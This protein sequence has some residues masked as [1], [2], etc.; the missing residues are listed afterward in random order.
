[1]VLNK[2]LFS[3]LKICAGRS[4]GQENPPAA[5]KIWEGMGKEIYQNLLVRKSAELIVQGLATCQLTSV[6]V[7]ESGIYQIEEYGQ[8][9]PL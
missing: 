6:T 2:Q 7:K 4:V 9:Y 5:Y 3:S 1:M 8:C